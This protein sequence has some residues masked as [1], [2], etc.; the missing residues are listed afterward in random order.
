MI[1]KSKKNRT[2]LIKEENLDSNEKYSDIYI[3][4]NNNTVYYINI[5]E[6]QC[7]F[8]LFLDD[9]TLLFIIIIKKIDYISFDID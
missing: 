5:K 1:K 4:N 2:Y 8:I 6:L 7:I 9:K 3:N